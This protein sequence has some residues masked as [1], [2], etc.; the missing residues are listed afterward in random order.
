VKAPLTSVGVG[1]CARRAPLCLFPRGVIHPTCGLDAATGAVPSYHR[2]GVPDGGASKLQTQVD[3]AH[4][5]LSCVIFFRLARLRR[6]FSWTLSRPLCN[7][8]FG[9]TSL[10]VRPVVCQACIRSFVGEGEHPCRTQGPV[11]V[12]L[13]AY[14]NIVPDIQYS[15]GTLCHL[16]RLSSVAFIPR[17]RWV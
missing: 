17:F 7:V 5:V 12:L 6:S 13:Q 2:L 8:F 10:M 9:P 4:V 3:V 16:V 15:M 14:L 1:I 11:L